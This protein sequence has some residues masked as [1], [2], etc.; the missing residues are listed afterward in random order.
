M[1]WLNYFFMVKLYV[2]SI[3]FS[4]ILQLSSTMESKKS[5]LLKDTTHLSVVSKLIVVVSS[6]VLDV[7]LR[8][9]INE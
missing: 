9:D 7:F 4:V 5:V 8:P 6:K 1:V 2:T 3:I